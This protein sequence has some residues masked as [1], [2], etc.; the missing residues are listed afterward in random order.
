MTP[1]QMQSVYPLFAQTWGARFLEQYGPQPNEAWSAALTNVSSEAARHALSALIQEGSAFPPTLPEF[2]AA[3]RSYRAPASTVPR[4]EG[5]VRLASTEELRASASSEVACF[6]T[7]NEYRASRSK[8][9][10]PPPHP[11]PGSPD[12]E[13]LHRLALLEAAAH[14]RR[15]GSEQ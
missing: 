3:A 12:W 15:A 7:Y 4:L 10:V 6:G 13:Y 2:V 5:P 1:H 8:F 14:N 11:T 9:K